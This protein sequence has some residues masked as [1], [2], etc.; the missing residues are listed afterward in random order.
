MGF[1]RKKS[2]HQIGSKIV[3][4]DLKKDA[5]SAPILSTFVDHFWDLHTEKRGENERKIQFF[6]CNS[7]ESTKFQKIKSEM[8]KTGQN[9]S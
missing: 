8:N 5:A 4:F 6:G 9:T 7:L 2:S 3:P 1:K